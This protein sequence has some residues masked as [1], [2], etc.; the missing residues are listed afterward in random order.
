MHGFHTFTTAFE[1]MTI[2]VSLA[3]LNFLIDFGGKLPHLQPSVFAVQ[4]VLPSVNW[5]P[6][7][8]L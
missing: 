3:K 4:T 6:A 5:K 7:E 8:H 1:Q 2:S